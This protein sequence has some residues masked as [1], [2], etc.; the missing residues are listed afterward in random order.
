M[1]YT[2]K[3]SGIAFLLLLTACGNSSGGD[4]NLVIDTTIQPPSATVVNTGTNTQTIVPPVAAPVAGNTGALNPEHGKPG[5]R[6]DIAVGA[7]LNSQPTATTTPAA[8]TQPAATVANNTVSFPSS[9]GTNT[10]APVTT[11]TAPGMNPAH[12]QP[13]H[14]CD[15]AVGA[16]LDSK[17][18]AATTTTT[19][20]PLTPSLPSATPVSP[21]TIPAAVPAATTAT[22]PG[23]NPPHGQPGH[24]CDISVGAPLNSKPTAPV[25][26]KGNAVN[27]PS[28]ADSKFLT[29][30]EKEKLELERNKEA[31]KAPTKGN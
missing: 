23:M 19:P 8:T 3:L 29:P 28:T 11:S 13:G 22:A 6:C 7:P 26:K 24:R 17:P 10:I 31:D 16:P 2:D 18:V 21:A 30:S 14:R 12:G 4:D 25:D 5:H 9:P 15:I 20:L 27:N 1:R